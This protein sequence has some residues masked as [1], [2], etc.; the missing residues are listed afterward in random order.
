[1]TTS[2][3][4]RCTWIAPSEDPDARLLVPGCME[5]VQDWDADCTCK[6]SA[7]ELDELEARVAE[8]EQQLDAQRDRYSSLHSADF[9]EWRKQKAAVRKANDM[10]GTE[11]PS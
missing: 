11:I 2:R 6:S 8:L 1:M 10:H 3:E 5:R 7:E 9:R 4:L